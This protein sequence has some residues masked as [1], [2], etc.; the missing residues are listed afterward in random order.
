MLYDLQTTS[1]KINPFNSHNHTEK[2]ILITIM[3]YE[4]YTGIH[5]FFFFN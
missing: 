3:G 2:Y 5:L 1:L 4:N